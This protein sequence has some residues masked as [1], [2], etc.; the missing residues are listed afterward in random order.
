M[1]LTD[2]DFFN[3]SKLELYNEVIKNLHEQEDDGTEE[4]EYQLDLE[5]EE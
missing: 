5:D 1:P 4:Q 3:D 2:D